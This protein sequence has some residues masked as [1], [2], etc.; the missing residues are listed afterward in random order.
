M[1]VLRVGFLPVVPSAI[2]C[3]RFCPRPTAPRLAV[4]RADGS[5]EVGR[6]ISI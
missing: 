6:I 3:V 5:I 1:E 2:R 4:A